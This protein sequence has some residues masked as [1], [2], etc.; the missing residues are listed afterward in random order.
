MQLKLQEK[1]FIIKILQ[2]QKLL[3]NRKDIFDE[4]DEEHF[5]IFFKQYFTIIQKEPI[6][7]SERVLYLMGR[8]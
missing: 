4:Y 6:R 1:Y 5:E 7:D 8:I 3:M 2:V